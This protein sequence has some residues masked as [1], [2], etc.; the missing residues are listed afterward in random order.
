MIHLTFPDGARRDFEAG[1]TG[2]D[3]AKGISPSLAKRTVAMALDGVVTDLHDPISRDARIELI[4]RDDPR[5]LDLPQRR[6]FRVVLTGRARGVHAVLEHVVI[7]ACAVRAR[8]RDAGVL[9]RIDAQRVDT[10]SS[11]Q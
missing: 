7:A 9:R 3:I 6:L 11:L 5:A 4:N 10:D 1:V 8:R 2:V